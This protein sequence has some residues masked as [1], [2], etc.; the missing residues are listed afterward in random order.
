MMGR[1][2]AGQHSMTVTPSVVMRTKSGLDPVEAQRSTVLV[3]QMEEP[4]ST[5]SHAHT[6]VDTVELGPRSSRC[7]PRIEMPSLSRSRTGFSRTSHCA[8][9]R[10]S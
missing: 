10:S 7:T 2:P 8:T 5:R 3:R 6:L 1:Y 4:H 9:I